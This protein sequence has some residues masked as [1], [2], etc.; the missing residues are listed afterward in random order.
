MFDPWVGKI[1]WTR[2]GKPLQ[3]SRLENLMDRGAWWATVHGVTKSRT[4]LSDY[5]RP[6]TG[7]SARLGLE[8]EMAF[9]VLVFLASRA[10]DQAP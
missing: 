5:T 10:K 4:R 7:I 6:H 3:F 1:P 8:G 2:Y 9:M